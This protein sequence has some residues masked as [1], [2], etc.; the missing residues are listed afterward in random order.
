M[1]ARMRAIVLALCALA[2]VATTAGA[3]LADEAPPDVGE[4]VLAQG[5]ETVRGALRGAD[6]EPVAEVAITVATADGEA[7]GEAVTD[8]D[9][10]WEVA[11]P[12]PGDYVVTLDAETL[13]EGRELRDPDR[14]PLEVSVRAAQNRT[15][16]F[17]LGEGAVGASFLDS[18]LSQSVSGLRFGLIIAITAIGLSLIFGTTGLVNFAHGELVALGAI[19]A[20]FFNAPASAGGFGLNLILAGVI[21]TILS[22]V[23]GG[24][25]ELGLWRP[26]RRRRTGLIQ[27]LVISIGLALLL[28]NGL[29][30][31]FG[32][33]RRTYY[34]YTIQTALQLGP[35]RITP[36]DLIVMALAATVLVGV[37]T[38]LQRTRIGKAMRA[39]SD[40]RDL[41]E[42][43]GIDVQRVIL[44]IWVLGGG[45]AGF[46]GLLAGVLEPVSY[47]MGFRLLLLMFAG[48]ILGGLG[49]AYGAMFGS[50]VV[51]LI[52]ELSTLWFSTELKYVWAL[53]VL[54]IILLVRPQGLLGRKERIG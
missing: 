31:W 51:G 50:I 30:V 38:M 10:A 40:N 34:D 37:A 17:A 14:N 44:V 27:M 39:V 15:L 32:G 48:V 54:I 36:R 41:A 13:P 6:G 28:R 9:G 4:V 19:I 3:A 45:L 2:I 21:A 16:I 35:I 24:A 42:S 43:S 7:V 22:A 33:G 12:G 26:L 29:Q 25:I 49:T 52:T 46:G 18:F 11:L 1:S 23:A 8:G 5:G 20:W 53:F 47:L